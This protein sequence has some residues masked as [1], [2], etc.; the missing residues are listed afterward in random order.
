MK[1]RHVTSVLEAKDATHGGRQTRHFIPAQREHHSTQKMNHQIA[2]DS[3]AVVLPA[4]QSGEAIFVKRNFRGVVEP[5]IP[6][7]R[8]RR[9]ITRCRSNPDSSRH[10]RASLT[11]HTPLLAM[12]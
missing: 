3:G 10:P 11:T 12:I 5:G 9:K 8:L 1:I 4:A 6:F 7:P 2:R